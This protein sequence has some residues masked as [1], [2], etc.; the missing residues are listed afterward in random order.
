[1][2]RFGWK[3][4][5]AAALVAAIS[6]ASVARGEEKE[7]ARELVRRV[8]DALPKQSFEA[9]MTVS[10][11]SFEPR[12][13]SMVSKYVEGAQGSYLEVT[14]PEELEGIRFL[15]MERANEPDDQYIKVKASRT[16][17]HV[18]EEVRRQP[19][20]ESAFYVSDLVR[21]NLDDYTYSYL[22][23]D[24]VGGR[25]TTLVQMTPKDLEKDIYSK[26]VV[27]L[28]PKDLLIMRREYYDKNGEKQKVWTVD[29]V[30]QIDGIWSLTGQEMHNVQDDS[31]SRLDISE[32][33]FNVEVPDTIFTP[34]YLL[35]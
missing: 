16:A 31:K 32:I 11:A 6:A 12:E 27:A 10:S 9:K 17:I 1:M 13:L 5:A 33:K 29:K 30:E 20:L 35:R 25:T 23:K 34:K 26:T 18:S 8:L 24:V 22:G 28:D 4:V 7:D 19:F 3:S 21:P 14:A 2:M 15:F